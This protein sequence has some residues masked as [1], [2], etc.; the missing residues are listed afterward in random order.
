MRNLELKQLAEFI[1]EGKQHGFAGGGQYRETSEG[2]KVFTYE[3]NGLLYFDSYSG[4]ESFT[5]NEG[6]K[7]KDEKDSIWSMSYRGRDLDE[8][9][10]HEIN[11]S[12]LKK[13]LMQVTPDFPFRGPLHFI[14]PQFPNHIYFNEVW[15]DITDFEGE[16]GVLH[17]VESAGRRT[18]RLKYGGGLSFDMKKL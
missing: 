11:T 12:F 14:D 17:F 5:G 3:K 9:I 6:V 10:Y 4:E 18:F 2:F 15:G 1:V 16:D 8:A 7:K 13:A